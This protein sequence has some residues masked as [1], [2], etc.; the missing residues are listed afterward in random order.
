MPV[1]MVYADHYVLWDTGRLYHTRFKGSPSDM[2]SD[3]CIFVDYS[4]SFMSIKHQVSIN[5]TKT[6]KAKITF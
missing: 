3:G 1:N 4:I 6:G 5:T 2:F